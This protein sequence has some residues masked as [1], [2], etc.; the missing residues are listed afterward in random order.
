MAGPLICQIEVQERVDQIGNRWLKRWSGNF[1]V[2]K[3]FE[4]GKERLCECGCM[5]RIELSKVEKEL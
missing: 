1:H 4:Y 3:D 5:V 2:A